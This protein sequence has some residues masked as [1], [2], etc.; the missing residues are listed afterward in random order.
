MMVVFYINPQFDLIV[1]IS[2]IIEKGNIIS[3][4]RKVGADAIG[5]VVNANEHAI[6]KDLVAVQN[7]CNFKI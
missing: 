1:V 4:D 6:V 2:H 5:N 7:D 3:R